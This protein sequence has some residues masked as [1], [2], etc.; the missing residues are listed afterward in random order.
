MNSV[1]IAI[2]DDDAL[3][4]KLLADFLG[5]QES[6]DVLFTAHSAEELLEVLSEKEQLPE[7]IVSDLKMKA[8]N[9][10]E[11]TSSLKTDYPEIQ[12]IIMSSHYN[13]SFMGF[14]LKMGVSA[15]V[16]KGITPQQLLSI[17]IEVHEKGVFFLEDQLEII[18]QQLSS[19][20]PKPVLEETQKLSERELEILRLICHQKTAKEIGDTL[21]IAPRTVE[22]HKNSL[23]AK[24]GAKNIAGL[25]IYGV[26]NKLINIEDIPM[27]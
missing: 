2:V 27:I 4:V 9:G 8:M 16:P 6:I 17:I 11:L 13:R 20:S 23:F 21:F 14:M 18:R 26:Q 3:I 12:T 24:T 1:S 15:F 19:K 25:V 22:G 5:A 7:I 10:A